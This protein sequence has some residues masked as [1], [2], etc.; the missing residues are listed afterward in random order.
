MYQKKKDRQIYLELHEK[1]LF[2]SVKLLI[3]AVWLQ[4]DIKE[5]TSHLLV[6]Q[7]FQVKVSLTNVSK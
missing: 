4:I 7:I 1:C 6:N 5:K 2:M 3:L